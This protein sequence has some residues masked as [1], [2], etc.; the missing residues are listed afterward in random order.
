MPHTLSASIAG[1]I[2]E[3]LAESEISLKD[4]EKSTGLAYSTLQRKINAG[5]GDFTVTEVAVISNALELSAGDM[6]HRAVNGG[7]A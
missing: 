2:K 5:L 1:Q 3:R 4:L 7:A 6:V